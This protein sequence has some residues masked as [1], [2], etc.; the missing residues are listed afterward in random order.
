MV[1]R[2]WE[3]RRRMLDALYVDRIRSC[4]AIELGV[5]V[6]SRSTPSNVLD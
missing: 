5:P 4:H 6:P 3:K 1:R 2:E